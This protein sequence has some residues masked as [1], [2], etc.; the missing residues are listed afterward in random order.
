[1]K[2]FKN[3]KFL[4]NSFL[5]KASKY[6]LDL[7]I[8]METVRSISCRLKSKIKKIQSEVREVI[9]S[10]RDLF[11]AFIFRCM[12]S[13]PIKF[14]ALEERVKRKTSQKGDSWKSQ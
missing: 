6:E 4:R 7:C 13:D 9:I 12:I 10:G 14:K 11:W 2:T 8:A 1:M 3:A 5:F